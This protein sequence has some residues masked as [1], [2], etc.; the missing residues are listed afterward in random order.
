[1]SDA[2]P[3][4]PCCGSSRTASRRHL[5][6]WLLDDAPLLT[7]FSWYSNR[8]PGACPPKSL[9]VV[10]LL[11]AL[12]VAIPAVGLWLLGHFLALQWLAVTALL[13][14][15]G[16]LFDVLMTYRRYKAWCGEWL[17]GECRAVFSLPAA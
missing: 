2:A 14:L 4:C 3:L 9:F 1:M 16:L 15:A 11:L 7:P 6:H 10:L 5:F 17:C 12:G 8:I 13:L